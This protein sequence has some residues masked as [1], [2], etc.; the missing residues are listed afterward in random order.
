MSRSSTIEE[1]LTCVYK[2]DYGFGMKMKE[3]NLVRGSV[4]E[5]QGEGKSKGGS[6]LDEIQHHWFIDFG[7]SAATNGNC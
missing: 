5:W 4:E 7:C 6:S 2:R 3:S 1:L